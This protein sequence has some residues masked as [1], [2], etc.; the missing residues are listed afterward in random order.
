MRVIAI[1][2]IFLSALVVCLQARYCFGSDYSEWL[3]RCEDH[4]ERVAQILAE[5]DVHADYYYL[6]V[7]ESKCTP[8]AESD[9]GAQGPWQLMPATA[10]HYGCDDP[11]DIECATR[12]AAAYIRHLE[13]MF[14]D[15]FADVVIAY[16]M[17]GRNYKRMG[18]TAEA[19]SLLWRV[20]R[21]KKHDG[22]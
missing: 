2:V 8:E 12:A 7:A 21:I 15:S 19:K 3:D 22:E 18:A 13:D 10:R 16:N 4:R 11:H 1:C 17:G 9:K 14:N 5:E 6:M 20:R